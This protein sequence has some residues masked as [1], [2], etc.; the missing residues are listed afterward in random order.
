MVINGRDQ[1]DTVKYTCD[2]CESFRITKQTF[3]K[4]IDEATSLTK[5][6]LKNQLSFVPMSI[7]LSLAKKDSLYY[8]ISNKH[9]DSCIAFTVDYQC[10]G[11]NGFGVENE[12]KSSN[13]I[14]V[15]GDSV[16]SNFNE[17]VRLPQIQIDFT[18]GGLNRQLFLRDDNTNDY[19]VIEPSAV[20][21][22]FLILNTSES[23][24]NR[25]ALL[26]IVFA[27]GTKTNFRNWNDFNCKGVSYYSLGSAD[28]ELFKTKKVAY[29]SFH[30]D[31]D[32]LARVP[33]NQS[34]Y[35][36]QYANLISR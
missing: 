34:D 11:K 14:F 6:S 27:D 13:I 18:S 28:L 15:V 7:K 26:T 35:F 23:C 30:D 17:E 24:V 10:I 9:V 21:N 36:M 4:V 2:S 19:M 8:Y 22:F 33:P 32:I 31:D 3:R 16:H 1:A 5:S 25:G 29:V 20:R 12:V